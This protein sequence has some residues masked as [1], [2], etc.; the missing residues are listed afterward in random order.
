MSKEKTVTQNN[1]TKQHL[2]QEDLAKKM[3]LGMPTNKVVASKVLTMKQVIQTR[4]NEVIH[5]TLCKE[6]QEFYYEIGETIVQHKGKDNGKKISG[7]QLV[8]PKEDCEFNGNTENGFAIGNP[9]L[10]IQG[11]K[12]QD[13]LYVVKNGK[14]IFFD[15]VK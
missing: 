15:D 7:Y 2:T 12:V 4:V 13:S 14:T 1:G 5:E 6:F 8:L 11:I 9:T 10:Y 3:G